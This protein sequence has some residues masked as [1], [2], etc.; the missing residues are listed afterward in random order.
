M[1]VAATFGAAQT[2]PMPSETIAATSLG[3]HSALPKLLRSES[4]DFF[5]WLVAGGVIGWLASVLMKANLV[6]PG[7]AR[8]IPSGSI[9]SHTLQGHDHKQ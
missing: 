2:Q 3:R 6:R 1:P 9:P 4:N 7:T 5:I 8:C